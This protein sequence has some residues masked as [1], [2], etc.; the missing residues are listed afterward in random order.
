LKKNHEDVGGN[1]YFKIH[2]NSEE[3][4]QKARIQFLENIQ[5]GRAEAEVKRQK[6]LK[7]L[8]ESGKRTAT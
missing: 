5:K 3:E 1:S 7:S 8:T 2:Y 4:E 6:A